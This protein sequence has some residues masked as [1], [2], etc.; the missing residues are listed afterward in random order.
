MYGHRAVYI[1]PTMREL[2]L[3]RSQTPA[4]TLHLMA[5][6]T[7]CLKFPPRMKMFFSRED[8]R[9]HFPPMAEQAG[10]PLLTG[11]GLRQIMCMPIIMRSCLRPEAAPLFLHAM[12]EAFS[13]PPT[14][15]L[16]GR[17]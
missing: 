7:W 12:T 1:I 5:I 3:Q 10:P 11:T 17:I 2:L 9:M 4:A 8:C 16:R 15:E 6:M 13:G 14:R